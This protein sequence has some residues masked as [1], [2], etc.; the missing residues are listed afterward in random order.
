EL[1]KRSLAAK[2]G[3][4]RAAA[5]DAEDGAGEGEKPSAKAKPSSKAKPK[6]TTSRASKSAASEPRKTTPRKKAG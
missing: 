4:A 1:L 6:S 3:K 2:P 5:D